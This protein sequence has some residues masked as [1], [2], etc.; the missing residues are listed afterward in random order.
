MDAF[1][2]R[3]AAALRRTS[4]AEGFMIAVGNG[5]PTWDAS[6]PRTGRRMTE[7]ASEVARKAVDMEDIAFVDAHGQ[8]S[9]VASPRLQFSVAFQ[10]NEA[11]ATLREC[12]LFLGAAAAEPRGGT[13]LS[14]FRHP[15]IAKT[16]GM[17]LTRT[18]RLDL[19]PRAPA[20]A[21]PARFLGNV[22][23]RELHDLENLTPQCQVDEIRADRRFL[24]AT[25]EEAV[26]AGYDFCAYC[27]GRERSTR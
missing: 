26:A 10:A 13:L 3:L 21:P 23:Q 15:R 1:Y 6:P 5:D 14:Y 20:A 7:L 11:V 4:G 2:L 19:T 8:P 17:V 22:N 27:F 18:I 12:G 16:E 24:F 9:A 25:I